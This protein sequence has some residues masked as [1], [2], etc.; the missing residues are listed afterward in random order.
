V[1]ASKQP[2]P[3]GFAKATVVGDYGPT[4]WN[5][6]WY[7]G[8]PSPGDTIA[9]VFNLIHDRLHAFYNT[10]WAPVLSPH[11]SVREYRITYRDAEDSL[12]RF[13]LADAIAGTG[14]D[15]GDQDAQVAYLINLATGDPRKGGKARKY[16][17]GVTITGMSDSARVTSGLQSSVNSSMS[18]WLAANLTATSGGATGLVATEMSFRN[19]NAWRD[20]PIGF[21]V[22]AVTLNTVV[23]TQRDR[24]DRL[25]G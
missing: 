25:R 13:T 19:A 10:I 2:I 16:I 20:T 22:H 3:V 11:W 5:N 23:A 24:V 21:E 14:S 9:D 18:S 6:V 15:A 7:F 4:F 12:V 17:P 8:V 1:A